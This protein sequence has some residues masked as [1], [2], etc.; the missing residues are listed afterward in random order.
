MIRFATASLA[1]LALV[2]AMLRGAEPGYDDPPI[3]AEDRSHWSFKPP[4][5][6]KLPAVKNA[7]WVKTPIDAFIL[8]KLEAAGIA[9][10][11][12]ADR[13]TLIRRVTLDLTGL[14]PTPDEVEAF[15]SDATPDA[16]ERL[17]D[18]LLASPHFGERQARH[19]LDVVRFAETQRLRGRRRT[20]AT[21]GVT[22]I[23]SSVHSTTTSRTTAS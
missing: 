3:T 11:P 9:P 16:Y 13:L 4:V 5:R 14:P 15:V 2:C 18:R 20:P 8:A 10:S 21:P 12:E 19:W 1:A 22:A 6:P 7:R 17:V 23:T